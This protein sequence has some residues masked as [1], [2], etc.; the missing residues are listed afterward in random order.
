M[1][2]QI[3]RLTAV[4]VRAHSAPGLYADGAGLYLQINK[5]GAKSWA[6]IFQWRGA[7]K[8]MGLGSLKVRSLAEAREAAD[9]ARKL[10]ADGINP[11][12]ERGDTRTT[13]RT[14]GALADQLLDALRPEW[15]N[16]KHVYQWEQSLKV[17]AAPLRSLDVDAVTTEDVLAVL[18]PIWAVKPETASR[19]RGR[20]ERVLD[21][22]KAKGLRTAEN[23]ARWKGHLALLLPKRQ[24]LYKGHHPALPFDEV[25]EFIGQLRARPAPAARALDLLILTASRTGEIVGAERSEFDLVKKI[26]TVPA[27]RM[28]GKVEHRVP[29]TDAA[30]KIVR[31]AWAEG[32]EFAKLNP[33]APT[34]WLFT[35]PTGMKPMSNM[36]MLMLLRRM[37]H[38]D[39]SVHGFRSTFRDWAGECTNFAREVV[40]AAL[41]HQV[42]NEVERAYR[43]GD[44][45]EKRRKLMDA[46]ASYIES[47]RTL[48]TLDTT[49]RM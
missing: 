47:A 5:T 32:D 27:E 49:K 38:D 35:D 23:P 25:S 16:A 43:R 37:G 48:V 10:V 34:R 15:K 39:I 41:A 42:G 6:F 30:V 7:R 19:T 21:A 24:K 2:H 8:Q 11:I 17:D 26:W 1:A 20:I 40:E 31:A 29:L 13:D 9:A 22:A 33:Q 28:K 18:K 14:F 46:W 12:E 4:A 36:A 3:K 44:A 45:L